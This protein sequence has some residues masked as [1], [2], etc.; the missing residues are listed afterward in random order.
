MAIGQNITLN[1][2]DRWLKERDGL[3]PGEHVRWVHTKFM[4]VDP[5]SD[6]PIVITGSANF[7]DASIETNHE[8]MLVIRGNTR[9]ADIYLGE[10]MRQFSSYAF[11]DAAY[12]AQHGGQAADFKP[13]DLA[14][15]A[16]WINRYKQAGSSG[17]LRKTY[18]SGE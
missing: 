11:R 13:Q 3:A 16:S 8:N 15:D 12:D 1:S 4:L 9:V 5:L 14:T 18:F 17:A 10:F 2:F 6:D 7:S